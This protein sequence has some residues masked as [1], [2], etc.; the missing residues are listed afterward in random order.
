[1]YRHFEKKFF[2]F[3]ANMSEQI[4]PSQFTLPQ[5]NSGRHSKDVWEHFTK[6]GSKSRGH[7]EATCNWCNTKW[8]HGSPASMEAHLASH[9]SQCPDD[10]RRIYMELIANRKEL[11]PIEEPL[12]KK[13][14]TKKNTAQT[15]LSKFYESTE[16]TE[17]R[18][19]EINRY[20]LI[21]FVCCNIP[22]SIIENPFFIE[23]LKHLRPGYNPPSRKYLSGRLLDNEVV[24][25]NLKVDT[26]FKFCNNLTLG[27]CKFYNII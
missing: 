4:P 18:I 19:D 6:G 14:K 17:Q 12:Q 23:A 21:A 5:K 10:I 26:T 20:L 2:F 13:Q 9:C 25:V 15:S 11:V 7:Y 24:S 27:K 22:F 3:E 8:G 16:L 1:M